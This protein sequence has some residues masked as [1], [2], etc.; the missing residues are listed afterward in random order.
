MKNLLFAIFALGFLFVACDKDDDMG[1]EEYKVDIEFKS[2]SD[3]ADVMM[4]HAMNTHIVFSREEGETVHNVVVEV[5]DA[6]GNVLETLIDKHVHAE[7]TYDFM[8]ADFTPSEM[9]EITLRATSYDHGNKSNGV[10]KEIKVNVVHGGGGDYPVSVTIMK[11]S[12]G[13]AVNAGEVLHVHV[14]FAHENN[15]TIHHVKVEVLDTDG[16]VVSTLAE[17]HVH[18]A[19]GAYSFHNMDYTPDAAGSFV[20][21]AVTLNHDKSIEKHA[22]AN[23]TVQ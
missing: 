17:E 3:G 10:T 1:H 7:T 9:G 4:G 11:P 12:E 21:R 16:N 22:M 5:L 15:E 19:S 8:N 23:F 6:D 20:L 14:E 2:P 18:E 13:E